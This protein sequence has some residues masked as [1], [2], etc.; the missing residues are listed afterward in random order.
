MRPER[1][2]GRGG[3]HIELMHCGIS[4]S[5]WCLSMLA[6]GICHARLGPA[7]RSRSEDEW[8]GIEPTSWIINVGYALSTTGM[9]SHNLKES[10]PTNP[11]MTP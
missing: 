5:T 4:E 9:L 10:Y 2:N 6:N 3:C 11:R 1:M 7:C 8:N